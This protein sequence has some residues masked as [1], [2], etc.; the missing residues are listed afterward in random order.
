MDAECQLQISNSLP[1]LKQGAAEL[2]A[3]LE[4]HD[5]PP[6]IGFAFDLALE[7]LVTN[8]IKYGYDDQNAH[9][10]RAVLTSGPDAI[11]LEVAD[12][13]HPFD[14]TLQPGPDL[15]LPAE[16]RPIGGLGLHLIRSLM[17]TFTYDRT[18]DGWNLV[19]VSKRII[20]L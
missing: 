14:P 8:T 13:G 9:K 18:P 12:D 19:R 10:I 16:D 17:D 3:F 11:T 7:E 15:S 20:R 5:V 4:H 6:E 1:G 2:R